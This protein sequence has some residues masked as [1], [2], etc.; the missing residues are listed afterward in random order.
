[1]QIKV[2][3]T[4]MNQNNKTANSL[5]LKLHHNNKTQI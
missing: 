4:K 1:V 3:E 5:I 2:V